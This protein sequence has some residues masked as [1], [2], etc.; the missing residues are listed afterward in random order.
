MAVPSSIAVIAP[1]LWQRPGLEEIK[2]RRGCNSVRRNR[3]WRASWSH[4]RGSA[5]APRWYGA[6]S[7]RRMQPLFMRRQG[8]LNPR[9]TSGVFPIL[10]SRSLQPNH[11]LQLRTNCFYSARRSPRHPA[12]NGLRAGRLRGS[13]RARSSWRCFEFTLNYIERAFHHAAPNSQTCARV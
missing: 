2:L 4:S 13:H 3:P 1:G 9:S 11:R 5:K 8:L 12:V 10:S 7:R 6:T